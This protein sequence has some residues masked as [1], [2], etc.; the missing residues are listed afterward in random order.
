MM[1]KSPELPDLVY[2]NPPVLIRPANPTPKHSIY[3]SNLDDQSFLRF[4]IKYVFVFQKGVSLCKLKRSLA[5]ALENYYPLAGRLR[6]SGGGPSSEIDRKLEVECNGEGA[7]LVEGFMDFTAAEFLQMADTPNRSWRKLLYRFEASSFL[8]IPPLIVQVT[9]LSCGGMILCTGINHCLSDGVGTSQ[10]LHAWAHITTKPN[11][12]LPIKPFHFRHVFKPRNPLHVTY[13]HPQ[14]SKT[15]PSNTHNNNNNNNLLNLLRSL[16]LRPVSVSLSA[17]QILRL[18]RR[19]I[20]SLKCTNFEALAAHTWQCW[21]HSLAVAAVVPLP[22]SLPVNLLFSVNVRRRLLLP[23][24]PSGFYGNAFVLACAQSSV[25]E[26]NAAAT[27]AN[28]HHGVTLVQQAKAAVTDEYVRSVVDM[29]D[30]RSVRTD[31]SSSLVI[32]QW[33]KLGLEDLDFGEGKPVNMGP[34]ASDIYCLFLPVAGD[35]NA[36]RVLVSVPECVAHKFEVYMKDC[37]Y[38][39]DEDEDRINN[40][41]GEQN[42]FI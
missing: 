11:L 42:S 15:T 29:L 19:C 41:N 37:C 5:I 31:M 21:L 23:E 6:V 14:Y 28:I 20:P 33:S 30:D 17:A 9:N 1:L 13:P 22:P 39:D 7:V 8:D 34:L 25:K 35:V 4:S 18:K 40:D 26:L 24:L 36:V 10:F 38:S 12:P 32:S 16:P 27:S 3:L 2:V